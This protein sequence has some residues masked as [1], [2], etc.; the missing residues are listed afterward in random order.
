M[1]RMAMRKNGRIHGWA[2]DGF[3]LV[4]GLC[5]GGSLAWASVPIVHQRN[6]VFDPG[7][8]EIPRGE[9]VQ[10]TNEDPFI[11]H[12]YIES[13][14]FT[15]DSGDQRPGRMIRISFDQPGEYVLKCAIH[16]KMQ[17]EISV[18]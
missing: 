5:L 11:H 18:K 14:N 2:T 1:A 16:L 7:R 9:S 8:V 10:F 3:V 17:L 6:N 15:Y 13:P 4:L 12:L